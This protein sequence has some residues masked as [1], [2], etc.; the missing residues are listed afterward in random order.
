MVR[1]LLISLLLFCGAANA[2]G[3]MWSS[4]EVTPLVDTYRL[5]V[6]INS[7]AGP[8]YFLPSTMKSFI[9]TGGTVTASDP[10]LSLTQT[11]N[12]GS[13]TFTAF[14]INVTNTASSTSYLQTW[15]VGG[16]TLG[17][18]DKA[19]V[20]GASTLASLVGAN[21]AASATAPTATTGASQAGKAV[22]VTASDAVA[23][24]DT[25]GAAA[26]GSVTIT[27]GAAARFTSGNANG[28]NINLV[29]GAGIGTGTAGQILISDDGTAAKPALAFDV[30]GNTGYGISYSGGAIQFSVNG[31][32]AASVNNSGFSMAG[33][34]GVVGNA[35]TPGPLY[36]FKRK[37]FDLSSSTTLT[38]GS[39]NGATITNSTAGAG[40]TSTLV[41]A[42]AGYNH[43][44]LDD[45]ASHRWTIKPN[46]SDTIIW[47]D[48]TVVTA[49]TGSIVSTGRYDMV[50]L[51]AID[52]TVWIASNVRGTWTVTP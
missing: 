25:A 28:G 42:A 17:Y 19:G 11:W 18:V 3:N 24:T 31:V 32:L 33:G 46:T 16:S 20:F 10:V 12:E 23:S 27:A 39:Y 2:Q 5:P 1:F 22:T 37:R 50:D 34:Y 26:G 35:T 36:G 47:T 14:D 40:I 45:N 15:R 49:A 52:A 43:R 8:R 21:L 4:T 13:T 48:G 6:A 41:T 30:S 9:E 38:S 29:T 44:M 51:E 7:T